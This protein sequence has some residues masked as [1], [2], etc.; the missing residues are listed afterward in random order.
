MIE[1]LWTQRVLFNFFLY[2]IYL[3]GNAFVEDDNGRFF[4]VKGSVNERVAVCDHDKPLITSLIR[5][6]LPAIDTEEFEDLDDLTKGKKFIR[7]WEK[8]CKYCRKITAF[9]CWIT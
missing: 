9:S 2:Q 7:I 3:Q 1:L 8:F 4:Y 5:R 6:E